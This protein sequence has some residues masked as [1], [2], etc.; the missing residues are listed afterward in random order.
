MPS[1]DAG[2]MPPTR[3]AGDGRADGRVEDSVELPGDGNKLPPWGDEAGGIN[4]LGELRRGELDAVSEQKP[5]SCELL[6]KTPSC[7]DPGCGGRAAQ[8][9]AGELRPLGPSLGSCAYGRST[10]WGEAGPPPRGCSEGCNAPGSAL[11]RAPGS[12]PESDPGGSPPGSV[13]GSGRDCG[14]RG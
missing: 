10:P 5:G 2:A 12:A 14:V 8:G 13:C 4:A 1:R 9:A 11:G 6:A 3:D 7:V